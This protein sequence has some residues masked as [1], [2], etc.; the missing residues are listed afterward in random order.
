MYSQKN[1]TSIL[2]INSANPRFHAGRTDMISKLKSFSI[3]SEVREFPDTPHT[4]WLFE[5]WFEPV[6]NHTLKFLDRVFK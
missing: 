3:Y 1:S 2:F 6:M 5:P 4:F